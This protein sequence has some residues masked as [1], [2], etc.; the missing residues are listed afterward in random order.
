MAGLPKKLLKRAEQILTEL[1]ASRANSENQ[2]T[3]FGW[4]DDV[5][6]PL[7]GGL[8]EEASGVDDE[9][10]KMISEADVDGMSPREALN[11]L[12]ELKSKVRELD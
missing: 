12:F 2:F 10:M 9:L 1:E 8:V 11:F 4:E 5:S 3:L 7:E 6:E